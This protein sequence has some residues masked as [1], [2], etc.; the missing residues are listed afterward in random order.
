M[1]VR[2]LS[3]LLLLGALDVYLLGWHWSDVGGN[4]EAQVIIV[5]PTVITQHLLMRQHVDRR[6]IEVRRHIDASRDTP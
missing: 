6:H 2:W 3:L 1:R 4:L 5:T